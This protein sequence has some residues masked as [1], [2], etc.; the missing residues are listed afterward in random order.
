MLET[1]SLSLRKWGFRL[2]EGASPEDMDAMAV[3]VE[4]GVQHSHAGQ[5]EQARVSNGG[6]VAFV[7][8]L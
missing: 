1:V 3:S 6:P 8:R 2:C 7:W 5:D 4:D